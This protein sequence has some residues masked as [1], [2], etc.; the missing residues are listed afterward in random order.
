MMAHISVFQLSWISC[1][2]R[3]NLDTGLLEMSTTKCK[4]SDLNPVGRRLLAVL[5]TLGVLEV[6]YFEEKDDQYVEFNNMTIIN[7]AIK[8]YGP[9]HERKLSSLLLLVQVTDK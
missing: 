2:F 7:L 3:I 6:K 9:T 1:D 8:L 5:G 4:L